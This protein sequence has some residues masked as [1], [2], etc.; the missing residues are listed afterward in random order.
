MIPLFSKPKIISEKDNQAVFEIESLYP[1]YGVTVG[2]SLRRV[3]ISSLPGA[4][5][6]KMK[7]KGVSHEFSTVPGVLEDVI[8]IMLNLK[9]LRFKIFSEEPQKA[10]LKIKGEKEVKGKDF[11][12]PS[13]LELINKDEHLASLTAKSA[14]LEIEIEVEKG[15]G[16]LP[17]EKRK[18]GKLAIGEILVDAIFTPVRKVGYQVENMRVGERTDFDK[19]RLEVETDGTITPVE[20][21]SRAAQILVDHFSLVSQSLVVEERTKAGTKEKK[22]RK[23]K[24][25]A[26]KKPVKKKPASSA[27]APARRKNK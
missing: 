17:R 2:N 23:K 20:A 13:Q 26:V 1:G 11:S 14:D 4:A 12:L 10:I 18:R 6:A 22:P 24:V 7:I 19:L 5:V 8:Q 27:G 25:G 3:L 9:K 21:V 16:Y 15:I